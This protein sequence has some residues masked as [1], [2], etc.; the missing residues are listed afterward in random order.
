MRINEVREQILIHYLGFGTEDAHKAWSSQW[1]VFNSKNLL[2]HLI[3]QVLRMA[4]QC[5]VLSESQ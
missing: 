2:S 5:K 3:E 4:E 1:V